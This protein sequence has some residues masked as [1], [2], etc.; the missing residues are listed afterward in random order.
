MGDRSEAAVSGLGEGGATGP[1]RAANTA[2]TAVVWEALAGLL[3]RLGGDSPLD[4][5]DA[6]GGTGGAAV[7]LAELGHRVTVVEPSPDSLAA[8]ERRAAERG[9]RVRGV[10][11]DTGDLATLFPEGSTDLVLVHN[12]L[13]YVDD[14]VAALRDVVGITRPGGAVSLLVTNAVAGALH[15]ALAGHL[16]DARALLEDAEGRW[17]PGDPIPRRFTR[18]GV[19][20]LV[21]AAGL[22]GERV[23]GVRVFADLVPGH[24]WEGDVHAGRHLVELEKAAADHPELLGIATQLHVT[25]HRP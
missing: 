12:V 19:L 21:G 24:A 18:R 10:Q 2:R 8:L 22:T 6:G 5:V 15:R 11:G 9:V 4:I 13:E 17:G 7:P 14:P 23:R 1:G 20:E 25:A 3:D 16:T